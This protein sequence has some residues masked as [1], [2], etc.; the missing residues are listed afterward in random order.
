MKIV[1]KYP[2]Q[3]Y[4]IVMKYPRH[5]M[6]IAMIYPRQYYENRNIQGNIMKNHNEISQA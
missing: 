1:M 5:N 6:K 4:E 3:Y 2:R